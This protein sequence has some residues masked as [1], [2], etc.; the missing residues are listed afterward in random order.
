MRV[1][2]TKIITSGI[3][4]TVLYSV[5]LQAESKIHA[6]ATGGVVYPI[7]EINAAQ[8]IKEKVE[9]NKDKLE[10]AFDKK[11]F[12]QQVLNYKPKNLSIV[13]QSALKD[14]T[15]YPNPNYTLD[16]DIL[17]NNNNI[18]YKKGY[19]FNPL[20][21]ITLTDRYVFLDYTNKKQVHWFKNTKLAKD[22]TTRIILTN[23][24]YTEAMKEFKREVFYASDILIKRFGLEATP[25][26]IQQDG[27]RIKVSHFVCDDKIK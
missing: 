18:L 12:K 10:Q 23:G 4:A 24:N 22:I 2:A 1:S 9:A 19:T 6:I 13:L 17:D 3:L 16:K 5:S 20:E 14:K 25:S 26:V 8:L 11:K 7:A 15:F 27:K 21:Y